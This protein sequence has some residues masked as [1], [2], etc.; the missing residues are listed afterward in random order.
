MGSVSQ[1]LEPQAR[2]RDA[3]HFQ[4][5]ILRRDIWGVQEDICRAVQTS[6]HIAVKG[7]HASGKTY[8]TSGLVP[9]F[10]AVNPESKVVTISPTLRQVKLMWEEIALATAKS[11]I[12]FPACG[13]TSLR[14]S[15]NRYAMGMPG[16][17]SGV[18]LHGIHAP[19]LLLIVDESPGIEAEIWDALEGISAGG[20]VVRVELG[21]PTV[22]SGH[23]YDNFNGRGSRLCKGMTISAFDTP[24][25]RGL[26]LE[27]LLELPDAEL[28]RNPLP[29][30]V[31]RRW[32]RDKYIKW[33][34]TNPRYQSRVLG[35]FPTESEFACFPQAWL[36]RAQR[37]ASTEEMDKIIKAKV[38]IRV[39]ID[40]AGP[41]RDETVLCAQAGGAIIKLQPWNMPDPLGPIVRE[42]NTLKHNGRLP[43]GPVLID[44]DGIGYHLAPRI[45]SHGFKV[46]L[47]RAGQSPLDQS[48][49]ANAKAE[50]H[51]NFREWLQ[52]DAVRGLADEEAL[53]QFD[54]HYHEN[55]RGLIQIETKDEMQ[56]RGISGS[57]DRAEAIMLAFAT[58]REAGQTVIY[59]DDYQISPY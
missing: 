37:E 5:E 55:S 7:C 19:K 41:G 25:L 29:F 53:A 30:L 13:S 58:V 57:P 38:P 16:G 21:N 23:F 40:V 59:Q 17:A 47:F 27:Q 34:P 14:L 11:K 39:G 1:V 44:G 50:M 22:P 10:L 12:A 56:K 18:A 45:A 52:A 43:L 15:D 28:D 24:N 8:V 31:T 36:E 51:W 26:T 33:G 32:V 4:R 2:A 9:W 54:I 6:R 3:A 49:Y 35:Q 42:L 46:Y 48:A 20:D